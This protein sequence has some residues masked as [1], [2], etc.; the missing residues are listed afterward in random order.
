MFLDS[1]GGMEEFNLRLFLMVTHSPY[2]ALPLGIIIT[3]DETTETLT[4]ALELFANALPGT[5]NHL[6]ICL[7]RSYHKA[8]LEFKSLYNLPVHSILIQFWFQNLFLKW[9]P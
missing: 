2:G 1:S 7:I 5:E 3:S 9:L 4:R 8:V 6:N